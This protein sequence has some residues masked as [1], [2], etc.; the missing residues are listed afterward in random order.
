MQIRTTEKSHTHSFN[1]DTEQSDDPYIRFFH[2]KTLKVS[3]EGNVNAYL[4]VFVDTTDIRKLEEATNSIR[5]QKIM[6]ASVSH[7]F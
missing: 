5:C 1:F 7:E 6:F 3:W 2:V 4:H